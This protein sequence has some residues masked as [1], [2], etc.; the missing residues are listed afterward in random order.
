MQSL[1]FCSYCLASNERFLITDMTSLTM[2][3]VASPRSGW[4][5]SVIRQ[6]P[7]LAETVLKIHGTS[8]LWNLRI[9]PITSR[10]TPHNLR[11]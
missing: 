9:L 3:E 10:A 4:R 1:A 7:F 11:A 5:P 8:G 2:P 6:C